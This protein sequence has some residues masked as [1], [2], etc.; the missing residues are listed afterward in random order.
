MGI[1]IR[2]RWSVRATASFDGADATAAAV[3]VIAL[4]QNDIAIIGID[5]SLSR[6]CSLSDGDEDGME[7]GR[8]A[9]VWVA[10]LAT[11]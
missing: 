9:M 10:S 5:H 3:I 4:Y 6:D 2:R 7:G 1:G 11:A 8:A